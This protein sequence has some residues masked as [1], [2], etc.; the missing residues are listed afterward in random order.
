MRAFLLGLVA[1]LLG[2]CSG[3]AGEVLIVATFTPPPA[4]VASNNLSYPTRLPDLARGEAIFAARCTSCHGTNGN[5]QGE[6]V[7]NGQVPAMPSFLDADH[8]RQQRPDAYFNIITNGNLEKL[9][10]PWRD[11]LSEQER[12]DVALYVYTLHYNEAQ[13]ARGAEVYATKCAE[14]HAADGSGAGEKMREYDTM[15]YTLNDFAEMAYIGD[16]AIYTAVVEGKGDIMPAMRDELSDEDIWAVAAY[17]RTA[18]TTTRS[19]QAQ[20]QPTA[21][22]DGTITVR[23]SVRHG[24]SGSTLPD[25]LTVT[26][27]YGSPQLGLNEFTTTLAPDG[28]YQ[29][30]SVPLVA[31]AGYLAFVRVDGR[32]FASNILLGEQL[33]QQPELPIMVYDLTDDPSVVRI[34][35]IS[36]IIE[37]FPEMQGVNSNGL[38]FRQVFTYENTSDKSYIV[39]RDGAEVSVLIQMPVGAIA[40]NVAQDP[41]FVVSAEQYAV[42]DTQPVPPGES[43]IELIYFVPYENGA[44]IDQPLNN[45]FSGKATLITSPKS[46]QVVGDNWQAVNEDAPMAHIYEATFDLKA[47]DVFKFEL[48]GNPSAAA[49]DAPIISGEAVVPLL[50]IVSGLAAL[51]FALFLTLRGRRA[52]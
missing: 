27:R 23:G 24:T 45:A 52:K 16:N 13:R 28:T 17:V 35:A 21:A 42:L 47:R 22:P 34:T 6:L 46:L 26:L 15:A 25:A 32:I 38:L 36:T 19:E 9:M 10:P 48:A 7:L 50:L 31:D 14:C 39:T 11:A 49:Q 44:V 29:V 4:Q 33:S 8:V 18:F 1:L 43:Q 30:D 12:W 5:G 3:L 20:A 2:A 41:R 51:G 40:L 37:P